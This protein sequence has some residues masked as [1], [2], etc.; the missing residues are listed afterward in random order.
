MERK[1][2]K[3]KYE[4]TNLEQWLSS[5]DDTNI[6]LATIPIPN[7]EKIPLVDLKFEKDSE[8]NVLITDNTDKMA[9][10]EFVN[11]LRQSKSRSNF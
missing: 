11:K 5:Y 3:N 2:D 1:K 7:L 10:I 4:E 9:A 8:W 6:I